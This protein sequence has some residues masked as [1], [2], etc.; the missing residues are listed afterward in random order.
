MC[1][2][3]FMNDNIYMYLRQRRKNTKHDANVIK[4]INSLFKG[5]TYLQDNLLLVKQELLLV[6]L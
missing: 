5:Y 6:D 2:I 1:I 4:V 3:L